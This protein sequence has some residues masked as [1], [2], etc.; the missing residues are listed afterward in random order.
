[1][2]I[3]NKWTLYDELIEGIPGE[4]RVEDFCV[5]LTWT[6]VRADCGWGVSMTVDQTA[7][8]EE[9]RRRLIGA[10]LREAAALAKS[11]DFREASIGMAA[12]NAYY[13][14]PD[15]AK[16]LGFFP[17]EGGPNKKADAFELFRN[18]A[19][20]KRVTVVGHFPHLEQQ[21]KPYCSLSILERK[22]QPGDYPDSAC[23]YILPEQDFVFITGV[24]LTNKT[25]PRLLELIR[26]DAQV[27]MVGPSVPLSETLHRFGADHLSGFCVTDGAALLEMIRRGAMM[28]L[29][30]AGT[31][32]NWSRVGM[33]TRPAQF[34]LN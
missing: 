26:P 33:E 11:W 27:C 28:E 22:P 23:E 12:M 19:S 10:S 3:E 4:L 8:P 31:R 25:L 18:A 20:G 21:L 9:P 5:G 6:A 14:S 29:F 1:M 7:G 24:T 30:S 16:A 32:V 17:P 34:I 15:R 13:N 2:N